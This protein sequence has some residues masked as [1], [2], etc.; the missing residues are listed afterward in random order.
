MLS[1]L[2][3]GRQC[4]RSPQ[5][6]ASASLPAPAARCAHRGRDRHR[7]AAAF[8]EPAMRTA[9]D[10]QALDPELERLVDEELARFDP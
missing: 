8:M 5:R 6:A 10:A 3:S 9:D 2:S 4:S 7:R 1:S